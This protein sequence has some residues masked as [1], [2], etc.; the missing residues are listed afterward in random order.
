MAGRAVRF[1]APTRV[2]Q[3]SADFDESTLEAA[4]QN[5]GALTNQTERKLI[6]MSFGRS[7][8][9]GASRYCGCAGGR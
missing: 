5:E 9:L 3:G 7:F 6:P 1:S 8:R 4:R 2:S